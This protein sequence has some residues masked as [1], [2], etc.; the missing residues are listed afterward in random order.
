LLVLQAQEILL[1]LHHHKEILV[2]LDHQTVLLAM[3]V[4]VA[5]QVVLAVVDLA[6]LAV[7][8]EQVAQELQILTVVRQ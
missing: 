7:L 4:A 6:Q 1:Q 8:V 3:A 2:D 5:D